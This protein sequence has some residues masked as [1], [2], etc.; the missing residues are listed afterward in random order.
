MATIDDSNYTITGIDL[1]FCATI[2]ASAL[3]EGTS[4]GVGSSFR[5]SARNMGNI[6]TAEF[7]PDVTYLEHFI[8]TA[9]GD[10]RRDHMVATSKTLTIPFTFDEINEDNF[11][12]YFYGSTVT[13]ASMTA[14]TPAFKVLTEEKI[15]GSAQLYCRTDIGNDFV[16]MIPKCMLS[17]DGNMAVNAEDWWNGPMKL[18]V[19]YHE[20]APTHLRAGSSAASQFTTYYGVISMASIS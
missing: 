10:R 11:K 7:A 8:T 19:L 12:R 20:W 6:V 18:D 5:T 4:N 1:Y 17:P 9:D 3:D 14:G 15:I 2:A 16:Y 13:E